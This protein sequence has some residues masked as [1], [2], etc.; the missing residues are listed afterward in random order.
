MK[1]REDKILGVRLS[2]LEA[3]QLEMVRTAFAKS[4][5]DIVWT[6]SRAVRVLIT[7][8]AMGVAVTAWVEREK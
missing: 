6:Q 8:A 2:A 4:R 7:A 5:P 1:T 3:E